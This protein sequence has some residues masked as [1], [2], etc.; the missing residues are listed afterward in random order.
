MKMGQSY[1]RIRK[2]SERR[3]RRNSGEVEAVYLSDPERVIERIIG[4]CLPPMGLAIARDP[5]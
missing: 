1:G 4:R 3:D 5:G 2:G